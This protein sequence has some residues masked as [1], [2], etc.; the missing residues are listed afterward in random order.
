MRTRTIAAT[1]AVLM[2]ASSGAGVSSAAPPRLPNADLTGYQL[3]NR[4]MG[5]LKA[6]NTAKIN[7]LLAPSFMVQRSNNTWTP[8]AA[9]MVNLPTIASYD[10]GFA[11]SAYSLGMLTVRWSVATHE[12]LPGV[13]VGTGQAPRLTTFVWT[14]AGFRMTSHANLNPPQR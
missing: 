5:N 9:Y 2:L 7:A 14:P 4:F 13:P 6:G 12:S 10:I 11:D 8:K 3:V 1:A